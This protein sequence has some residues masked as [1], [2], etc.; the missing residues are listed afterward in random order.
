MKYCKL[1]VWHEG[2][3]LTHIINE[4]SWLW[5]SLAAISIFKKPGL[6]IPS[7][8]ASQLQEQWKLAS[9][10]FLTLDLPL[11][12]YWKLKAERNMRYE[13]LEYTD[14]WNLKKL[15]GM[16]KKGIGIHFFAFTG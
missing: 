6:R 3:E 16:K 10:S 5:S 9:Q 13:L 1:Q 12:D 15:W 14:N 4:P 2:K 7:I 8:N 11:K